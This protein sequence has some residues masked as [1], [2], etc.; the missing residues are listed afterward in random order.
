MG[1]YAG[2]YG[3]SRGYMDKG[4]WNC[5]CTCEEG[6]LSPSCDKCNYAWDGRPRPESDIERER[7]RRMNNAAQRVAN[8]LSLLFTEA[9]SNKIKYDVDVID[10]TDCGG[11]GFSGR[12]TGYDAMCDNCAGH[13]VVP[14]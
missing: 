10:C 3:S 12:G 11:S 2:V 6:E 7:K 8:E 4:S 1:T 13:G 5:I 14:K 9:D